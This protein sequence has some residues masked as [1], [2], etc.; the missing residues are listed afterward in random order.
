MGKIPADD[1]TVKDPRPEPETTY[2][3]IGPADPDSL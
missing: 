1:T 2:V 3:V